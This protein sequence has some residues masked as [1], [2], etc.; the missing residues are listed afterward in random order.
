MTTL[1][2]PAPVRTEVVQ[3]LAP[4]PLWDSLPMGSSAAGLTQPWITE[5]TEDT[6]AT[7]FTSMLAGENGTSPA[8][9]AAMAPRT[10]VG[11]APG[12]PYRLFQ[13]LSQRYYFVAAELVCRRPG[14]PDHA[15]QP[16]LKERTTFVMRRLSATGEEEGFVPGTGKSG[17]WLPAPPTA[18]LDGEKE[19]P[20]HPA[21]IAPY[22]PAGAKTAALGLDAATGPGRTLFYGYVPVAMGETMRRPM[23]DPAQAFADL[24]AKPAP[25]GGWPDPILSWLQARV[26]DPWAGHVQRPPA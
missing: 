5:L 22:A 25:P 16:K 17:T 12:A 15:V 7:D 20:M 6:F 13:P 24:V 26:L 19:H 3:W 2:V 8:D 18:L 9:L 4:A 23:A 14:I 1:A 21:P 10:T 11:D